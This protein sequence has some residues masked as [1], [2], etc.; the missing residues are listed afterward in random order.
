MTLPPMGT[1]IFEDSKP[2]VTLRTSRYP[3]YVLRR[4]ADTASL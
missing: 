3:D 1:R 2:V 4:L